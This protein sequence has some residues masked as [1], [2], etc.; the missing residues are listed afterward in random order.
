MYAPPEVL[1]VGEGDG[2]DD[3]VDLPE[4]VSDLLDR[5]LDVGVVAHVA[6]DGLR[7]AR[8]VRDQ[9]FDGAAHPLVLVRDGKLRPGLMQYLGDGP[10]DAPMV[11]DAEHD[12]GLSVQVNRV[13]GCFLPRLEWCLPAHCRQGSGKRKGERH[14]TAACSERCAEVD[15]D[16]LIW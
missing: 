6:L 11:R 4:P 10:R 12:A 8:P 7:V 15:M 13:H 9:L 2:V 1:A 14:T 3:D 16:K 5:A